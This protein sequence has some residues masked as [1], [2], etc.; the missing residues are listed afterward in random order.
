[1]GWQEVGPLLCSNLRKAKG[2]VLGV[3]GA[4]LILGRG[5]QD[6]DD[7]D[8]LI[9]TALPWEERL[10]QQQFSEYTASRP[11]IYFRTS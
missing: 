2:L 1:M 7:F 9:H 3:H 6:L 10:S 8:E 5:A 11:T 4:N